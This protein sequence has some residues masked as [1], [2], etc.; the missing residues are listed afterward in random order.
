[1]ATELTAE[2]GRR[3]PSTKRANSFSR[4]RSR[5]RLFIK[6]A[7]CV[8]AALLF[9]SFVATTA[10]FAYLYSRYSKIVDQRLAS[11]YLTSRAGIYA[12][13]RVLRPGQKLTAE[14]LSEILRRAGYVDGEASRVWN[15]RFYVDGDGV[16][17]RPTGAGETAAAQGFNVVHIGFDRRGQI[18]SITGDGARLASYTLEPEPLTADAGEKTA[19]RAALSYDE[20]PPVVARAVLS[21]EDRRFFEHGPVDFWGI[22]RAA[23]SWGQEDQD[24]KQGGSTVTQQLVKNTY[25]TPERTFR[26]KFQEAALASVIEGQMSKKDILALYCNEIY[27]G[28]RGSIAVRG[29][30]QAARIFFG[31]ELQDLSLAEAATIA[32]MIQSPA[33]YAPDRHPDKAQLRRNT[34]LAAMLRDG[35]ITPDEARAA[36]SEPVKVAPLEHADAIA[37]YFIDYAS[38]VVESRLPP[39]AAESGPSQR[40]YTTLDLD[41][42]QIAEESIN[43]QLARLEKVFKGRRRPQAALVALDPRTGHVLALV[44]G[45]S[46]AGSQL[47]RATDAL[48]QPGSVFKPVVY[49][50]AL[51]SGISPLTLSTDAPREFTYDGGAKYRPANY[52]GSF[53]MHD[54]TLRT[55]LVHSLNVVTVDAALR[56]GLA[57]VAALAERLGLPRPQAYPSLALGTTEATPL[58]VATAYTAFA[59]GGRI[60][61]PNP[62]LRVEGVDGASMLE[63]DNGG[64][65]EGSSADALNENGAPS[66]AENNAAA[67]Q[68]LKPST[69]Y[70]L[71]DMLSAVIDHGT[72]RAAR[73]AIRGVA[74]AGKTGTSRDG[75][76]A[77]FTPNLVCVVWVGFDDGEELNLT[78]ADSAL[79]AWVEFVRRAVELRPELGGQSFERPASVVTVDIDPDT[80]MLASPSC[81]QHE[82]VV[83]AP[84]FVPDHECSLH[85]DPWGLR[86]LAAASPAEQP[87]PAQAAA[88]VDVRD[89]AEGSYAPTTPA[90]YSTRRDAGATLIEAA[91]REAK[92]TNGAGRATQIVTGGDGRRRLTNDLRVIP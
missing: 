69:A 74:V 8:V 42:Q 64:M 6:R 53:S 11:G 5:R 81:P 23:F 87:S 21:I 16:E 7:L 60:V 61:R 55:G 50:A 73:G 19:S 58:E 41:L 15:G 68:V 22:A 34:V 77:G 62:V 39:S 35:A 79:P 46:Y 36:A 38:R 91:V 1:M 82:S 65:L 54:V 37:P 88:A 49:A 86:A 9:V 66:L 29:V 52:G 89:V 76:F 83:V 51:E 90:A 10:A 4:P 27:L 13:P 71:T 75:W 18:E 70:M 56:T 32:G 85:G 31:K 43:N 40:V 78:G 57:R 24:F 44:G 12:A 48:R 59:G 28:R 45:D 17:I 2:H 26:R 80:G 92:L 72:A 47:N 20:I 30:R 63:E 3:L 14:H 33:R 25:L 84:A 67:E